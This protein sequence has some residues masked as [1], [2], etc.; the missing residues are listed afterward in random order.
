MAKSNFSEQQAVRELAYF[1]WQREGRP[2][3]CAVEHWRR[4]Q[5]IRS[6]LR[7]NPEDGFEHDVEAVLNGDPRADFPALLTKD[8][9]GG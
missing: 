3:G 9:S 2:D 1:L 8:V 6:E 4:A 5:A 7:R